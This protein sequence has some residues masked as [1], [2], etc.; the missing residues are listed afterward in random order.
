M[1]KVDIMSYILEGLKD[2]VINEGGWIKATVVKGNLGE[3][4]PEG[5]DVFIRKDD[6]LKDTWLVYSPDSNRGRKVSTIQAQD[7]ISTYRNGNTKKPIPADDNADIEAKYQKVS[8]VL[9]MD[10]KWVGD[11]DKWNKAKSIVKDK[12]KK[13]ETDEQ[14]FWKLVTGIYKKMGGTI[15]KK[16]VSEAGELA[17]M[18]LEDYLK[19]FDWS[20]EIFYNGDGSV[21]TIYK[22]QQNNPEGF[23]SV[24]L[25]DKGHI[26]LYQGDNKLL[27]D[28]D[29]YEGLSDY[30][31][32]MMFNEHIGESVE[33]GYVYDKA[34]QDNNYI[35]D[36]LSSIYVDSRDPSEYDS[37]SLSDYLVAYLDVVKRYRTIQEFADDVQKSGVITYNM[38]Y[39]LIYVL[40]RLYRIMKYIGVTSLLDS[41]SAGAV[42]FADYANQ[43]NE[44]TLIAR[45]VLNFRVPTIATLNAKVQYQEALGKLLQV[46]K[47]EQ[48]LVNDLLL[49]YMLGFKPDKTFTFDTINKSYFNLANL[50]RFN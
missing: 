6:K 36:V 42:K 50:I 26:T 46:Y 43:N 18:S 19:Y 24:E 11:K 48:A 5:K 41:M 33:E 17:P 37:D 22:L 25:D 8:N 15:L 16:A 27:G 49:A 23:L 13:S 28:F 29:S 39:P 4:F 47:S 12:Y 31:V 7:S 3:G 40:G 35:D 30:L 9:Y 32:S 44:Y 38:D 34:L 20:K 2:Y 21:K 10:P 14:D 45:E 1:S